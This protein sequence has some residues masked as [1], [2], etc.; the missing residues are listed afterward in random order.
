[1][2]EGKI[3]TIDK[4]I[5]YIFHTPENIN[6]AILIQMMKQLIVSHGGTL[7]GP[8]APDDKHVIYDGGIEE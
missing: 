2:M 1:M 8:D 3:M 7:D 5:E 6:K 4:V